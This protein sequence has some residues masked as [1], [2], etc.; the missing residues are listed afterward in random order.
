[1]TYSNSLKNYAYQYLKSQFPNWVHKGV[2]GR[3]AVEE[4]G[5]LNENVGRRLREL[6]NDG[7]I[8]VRYVKSLGG[9]RCA[10]YR[11]NPPEPL[12]VGEERLVELA[13]AGNL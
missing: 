11:W 6:Q 2:I 1:M 13:R 8:E 3:L 10:E 4:W 9:A 5:Y 12:K 7:R